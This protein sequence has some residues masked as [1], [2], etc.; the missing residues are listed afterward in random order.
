VSITA[1]CRRIFAIFFIFLGIPVLAFGHEF[2]S[3]DH[4]SGGPEY[5]T[6]VPQ[7]TIDSTTVL[8]DTND[9]LGPYRISSHVVSPHG[10]AGV[11]LYHRTDVDSFYAVT[12]MGHI[13][14]DIYAADLDGPGRGGG[15]E[16]YFIHAIDSAFTVGRDPV[17]APL[18]TYVFRI[19]Y[20]P[21]FFP[22]DSV[23][24]L[25]SFPPGRDFSHQWE[26]FDNDGDLDLYLALPSQ[27]EPNRL[28]RYEGER[29]FTDVSD[30][31]GAALPGWA[32][33][34]TASGDCDN[35]GFEDLA[36]I[37]ALSP[38]FL[39]RNR[40][41][42]TF[43]D[44]SSQAGFTD[45]LLSPKSL[46]WTD[47]DVDGFVDLL[48]VAEDGVFLYMNEGGVSFEDEAAVRELPY[49]DGDYLD[50][51]S[52]DAD[53]DGDSEILFLGERSRFFTNESGYYRDTTSRSGLGIEADSGSLLDVGRDG[54]LDLVLSAATVMFFENDGDGVFTD[55]TSF[56]GASGIPGSEP[57]AGDINVD[58]SPD[59]GLGDGNL[60]L[61]DV[62]PEFLNVSPFS[63]I[64][65]PF[66]FIDVNVDG[67]TD[68]YVWLNRLW[69]GNGFLHGV[70]NGWIE[71]EL[72]GLENNRS[73]IGA[74]AVLHAGSRTIA[75]AVSGASPLP[76]RLCFGFEGEDPDSLVIRWPSGTVQVERTLQANTLFE[77]VEDT[78]LTWVPGE[79]SPSRI[80]SSVILY[81]NY[82]NP[83]NPA[84]TIR[85]DVPP[86]PGGKQHV[87]LAVYSVRGRQV[88]TLIDGELETGSHRAVW[89]GNDEDGRPVASGVFFCTARTAS[90]TTIRKMTLLR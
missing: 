20:M 2:R 57:A 80:P 65:E 26:D 43:E 44:V 6:P 86:T 32:C 36:V 79:S 35:D 62:K 10:I 59:F 77:V 38:P 7:L 64:T 42:G 68:I 89:D 22:P 58:G 78:T 90:G 27:N 9:L 83:F 11:F 12:P 50:A 45:G 84:T 15:M 24:G 1:S 17:N 49:A 87:L 34:G 47:A 88:R 29:T 55:V 60:Y 23:T 71:V 19:Y 81:Q 37:A 75:G 46:L 61:M 48:V 21:D 63:G 56:Y 85:F 67:F 5:I 82:P 41:D 72:S 28:F 54:D 16:R 25:A 31:S 3:A 51:V 76:K 66:S 74:V 30:L 4:G 70:E 14:D 33:L 52:F 69:F 13:G 73:A 39:L 53:G 18:D 40:G 8:E